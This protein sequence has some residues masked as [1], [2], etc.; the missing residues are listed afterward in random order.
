M[1][2]YMLRA[3]LYGIAQQSM[4]LHTSDSYRKSY[5]GFWLTPRSMTPLNCY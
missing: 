5:T 3:A 1:H 4:H 2:N